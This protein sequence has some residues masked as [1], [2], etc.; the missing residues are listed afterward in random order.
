MG[1]N[2]QLNGIKDNL[3]KYYKSEWVTFLRLPF[4][5]V[6]AASKSTGICPFLS[7]HYASCSNTLV[8]V[9]IVIKSI[10]P[11]FLLLRL[12]YLALCVCLTRDGPTTRDVVSADALL[13]CVNGI[14]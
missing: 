1:N 6:W 2:H 9:I 7:F 13:H 11:V 14:V 10:H 5:P 8:Y 12:F 3:R 4:V